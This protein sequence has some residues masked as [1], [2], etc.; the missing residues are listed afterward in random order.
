VAAVFAAGEIDYRMVAALVRCSD[1]VTDDELLAQLDTALA[2]RAPRWMAMSG[3]KLDER[4]GMWVEKYDPTGR[5]KPP[6]P[7]ADFYVEI[8]PTS[9]NRAGIWATVSLTDGAAWDARLDEV[10]STVCSD[11]PRTVRQRRVDALNALRDNRT[12]LNC[13]CGSAHCAATTT[14][15]AKPLTDVVINVIAESATLDGTSDAPGYLPGF[16]PVPAPMLRELLDTAT[17]V[18][19]GLPPR[20][21]E[22]GYRP[23]AALARWVR[24]RDL[25]CRFPGCDAPA[26]ICDIDHTVAYPA[27]PTHP[28]NLKLLC[29]FHHLLKTFHANWHDEQLP[30]GTVVWTS[31]TGTVHITTPAGAMFFPS[32]A[33]PTG[34][35]WTTE[36]TASPARGLMM[37]LRRRTRVQDRACRIALERQHNTERLSRKKL[38]LAERGAR[39]DEPPPP[40]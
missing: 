22:Q 23:S 31:P 24:C 29:R 8:G 27:G 19:I 1:N 36:P 28:S 16:G 17:L 25:T 18:Q 35:V 11:D 37:P 20:E 4:I 30:D 6:A 21:C 34:P 7:G 15:P 12:H 3:P 26:G 40:F 13:G 32:L 33:A 38:L 5:R 2:Q 10:A 9:G 14:D 39:D